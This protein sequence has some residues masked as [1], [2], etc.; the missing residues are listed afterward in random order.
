MADEKK[1]VVFPGGPTVEWVEKTKE[2]VGDV[3]TTA[4]NDEIF[5]FRLLTRTEYKNII[6]S[7]DGDGFTREDDVCS[8]CV[9]WP[10]EAATKFKANGYPAGYPGTISDAILRESGF[11]GEVQ[12]KKL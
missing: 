11:V 10:E 5:I 12:V 3:F 6:S 9:L 4:I 8:A 1:E 2:A 7:M